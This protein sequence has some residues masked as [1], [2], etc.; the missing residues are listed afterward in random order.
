M[1]KSESLELEIA[2]RKLKKKKV[3]CKISLPS[4]KILRNKPDQ[5]GEINPQT[6][7]QFIFDKGGKNIQWKKKKSLFSKGCWDSWTYAC[8]SMKKLEHH[9]QK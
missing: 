6:Y 1:L 5:E 8:K 4:N 3:P 2:E 9:R 7:G